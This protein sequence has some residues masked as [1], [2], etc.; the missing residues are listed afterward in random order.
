MPSSMPRCQA[1]GVGD[2]EIVA[3][4][5][6]ARA[7]RLRQRLPALPVVLRHAVLDGDDGIAL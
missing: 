7:H 2:E 1:L 3:D 5:L 4:E 6:A